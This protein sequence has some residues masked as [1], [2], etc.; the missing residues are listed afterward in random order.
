MILGPVLTFLAVGIYGFIHSLLAS[1][2]AKAKAAFC[3]GEK[4]Q[5]GYRLI[6]NLL[7]G[8]LFLP[9]LALVASFPGPVLYRVTGPWLLLTT[10]AQVAA[11]I[12]LVLGVLQTDAWHFL[13]ISQWVHGEREGSGELVVRGLYRFV[14][15]PLYTAGLLFLWATPL[16]TA[17]ILALNISL[18]IYIYLGTFFEERRLEGQ[19]GRAYRRY[20]A[21]V[22]RLIPCRG[23]WKQGSEESH[24]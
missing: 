2:A 14:R 20:Q 21:R 3:L 24:G 16:M 23:I 19:F 4:A 11:I 17:S 9:I 18:S 5:R 8:L 1:P 13:G 7:G 6:Y 15:H 12:V 10:A 22:P